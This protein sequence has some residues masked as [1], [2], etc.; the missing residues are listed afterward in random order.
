M[1]A[2]KNKS[3]HEQAR[4]DTLV[5]C[6]AMIEAVFL[7]APFDGWTP[8]ALA[9][10]EDSLMDRFGEGAGY[11]AFPGGLADMAT[12]ASD[13]L[14]RKMLAVLDD[15]DLAAMK[16]R[17]RVIAG[18]R[19][20][21]EVCQPLAGIFGAAGQKAAG[22]TPSVGDVQPHLVRGWRQCHGLQLLHQARFVVPGL[23]D[24]V[25]VLVGR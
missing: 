23:Y 1:T 7:H 16:V 13:Y 5:L 3:V 17:D 8:K 14:D 9:A 15:Q 18:V 24:H 19:A 2:A 22:R 11:R 21:I 6:D 20:R 10:A 4:D 25:A 12:Y